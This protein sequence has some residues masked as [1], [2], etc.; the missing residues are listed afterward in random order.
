MEKISEDLSSLWPEQL[1]NLFF[2]LQP[3]CPKSLAIK[4]VTRFLRALTILYVE[5]SVKT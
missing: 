3:E 4:E 2:C 1:L 5:S